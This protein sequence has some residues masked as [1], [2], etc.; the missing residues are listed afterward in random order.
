LSP[1]LTKRA[2]SAAVILF[3]AI[4]FM[5]KLFQWC[6]INKYLHDKQDLPTIFEGSDSTKI[7]NFATTTREEY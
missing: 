1:F 7:D 6:K 5:F 2:A 3:N 4:K